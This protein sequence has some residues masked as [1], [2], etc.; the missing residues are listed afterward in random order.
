MVSEIDGNFVLWTDFG[1]VKEAFMEATSEG[2]SRR[3]T[4]YT[5]LKIRS[6]RF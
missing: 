3:A 2:K 5:K 6:Y 1:W 4:W